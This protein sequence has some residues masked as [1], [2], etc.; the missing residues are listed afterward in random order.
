MVYDNVN[1]LKYNIITGYFLLNYSVNLS[2]QNIN[3]NC[4][5][6]DV[7]YLKIISHI[8]YIILSI[9]MEKYIQETHKQVFISNE[10]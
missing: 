7:K 10:S 3:N 5:I 4:T 6:I 9:E 2:L 8:L 1:T